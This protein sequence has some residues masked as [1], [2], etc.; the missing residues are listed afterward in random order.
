MVRAR[1]KIDIAI[2]KTN[3]GFRKDISEMLQAH[4]QYTCKGISRVSIHRQAS[5]SGNLKCWRIKLPDLKP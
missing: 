4:S 3:L 5:Y 1:L 2:C